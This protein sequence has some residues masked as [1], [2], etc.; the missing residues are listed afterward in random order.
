M[1]TKPKLSRRSVLKGA[2]AG[3]SYVF[4]PTLT[5]AQTSDG[6]FELRAAKASHKLA[7]DKYAASDLWLYNGETPGPEIRVKQGERVRVHFINEL[8]EPTSVHWHG[9]RIDNKMDGVSGL[10][11]DAVPPGGTFDYD[12]EVPDSGTFWYHAHNKSWEQVARGL[13]GPLIVDE[14]E[15]AVDR[16]H[17]ITLMIDDWRLAENGALDVA[18]MGA[19]MD[20]SHAGRLGNWVTVNGKSQPE[21]TLNAGEAYRLRLVNASNARILQI[22]PKAIGAKVIGYDGF[23]FKQAR[24]HTQGVLSLTPAQRVDLLITGGST[25]EADL[26]DIGDFALQELSGQ[27]PLSLAKFKFAGTKEANAQPVVLT[28][29]SIVAPDLEGAKKFP[30]IMTGGAMGRLGSV[31]YNGKILGSTDY[32][33]AKQVWA[34]NGI[35]NLAV[36]P[37]F[38]VKRGETVLI[39]T[40]NETGWPHGMHVHGHHF[41]IISLNGEE[42]SDRDWRDTFLIDRDET[43]GVAFVADNPGKWLLHCHMLEHAAAGMQTWFEVI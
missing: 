26:N 7:G 5:L 19:F 40:T 6:V 11:Q 13:Y 36:E 2:A 18:S 33:T 27:A 9:I 28:P 39:E 41:Q 42:L 30:L 17:D 32:Q 38:R 29:N 16:D 15:P 43:V 10:T 22:D 8:D 3:F 34:F 21:L 24:N 23:V 35:A 31:T 4:L 25:F 1:E 14:P 12:F 37:F 20:W